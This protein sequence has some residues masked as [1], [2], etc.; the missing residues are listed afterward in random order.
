[1]VKA[2]L[3]WTTSF[4]KESQ[5]LIILLCPNNLIWREWSIALCPS[6]KGVSYI[7]DP[8]KCHFF[9]FECLILSATYRIRLAFFH[10]LLRVYWLVSH[11]HIYPSR[12]MLG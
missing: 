2:N 9:T 6:V 7:I 5:D 8:Q 3:I 10:K 4:F 12:N 1:M 11:C